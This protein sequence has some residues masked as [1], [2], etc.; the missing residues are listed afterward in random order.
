MICTLA[1]TNKNDEELEFVCDA[2]DTA[3][4]GLIGYSLERDK[5]LER[6]KGIYKVKTITLNKLLEDYNAPRDIDYISIDTEGN[7][8]EILADFDFNK[9]NV[10]LFTIEHNFDKNKL[11]ILRY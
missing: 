4:S 3:V 10:K 8:A 5:K 9:W 2:E 7:E 1:V 6:V 11:D